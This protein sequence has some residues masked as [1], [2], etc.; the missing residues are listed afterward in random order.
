MRNSVW[1]SFFMF[2]VIVP[3]TLCL[4]KCLQKLRR[5]TSFAWFWYTADLTV[6]Q[7]SVLQRYV[8][9]SAL[10]ASFVGWDFSVTVCTS[11]TTTFCL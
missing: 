7:S 2:Y 4:T 1:M 3:A 5:H 8:T 6:N 9:F 10:Y 11:Q